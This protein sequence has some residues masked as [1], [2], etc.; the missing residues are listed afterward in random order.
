MTMATPLL[1]WFV[2]RRL[3]LAVINLRANFEICNF[4]RCDAKC[5]IFNLGYMSDS[6]SL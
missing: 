4:T 3:G 2:I 5:G 6:K 1:R